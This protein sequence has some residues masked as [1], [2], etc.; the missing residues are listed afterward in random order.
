[1]KKFNTNLLIFLLHRFY[2]CKTNG[3]KA[4]KNVVKPLNVD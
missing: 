3:N 1:M 4:K 2:E